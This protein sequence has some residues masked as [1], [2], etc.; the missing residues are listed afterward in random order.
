MAFVRR[1]VPLSLVLGAAVTAGV[2][3]A[4]QPAAD[5]AAAFTVRDEMVP[6]RDGA[7][8]FTK[9][10]TPKNQDGPLPIVFRRTPYGID[11]AAN[12]FTRYYKALADEAAQIEAQH[13]AA[14][15]TRDQM[16]L[17][18][19]ERYTLPASNGAKT[20][21]TAGRTPAA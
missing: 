13:G 7:R 9:I 19:N 15:D 3:V 10:F 4:R 16:K 20:S 8:L 5:P 17:L 11:G 21:L 18:V 1:L 12:A 2:L 14:A 6:M